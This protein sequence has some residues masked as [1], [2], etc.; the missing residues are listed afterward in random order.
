LD[1]LSSG[2]AVLGM[3]EVTWDIQDLYVVKRRM[4]TMAYYVPKADTILFSLKVYFDEQSGGYYHIIKDMT[5]L[6]LGDGTPMVF[7]YQPGNTL[8]MMLM[9]RHFNKPTT[10]VGLTFEDINMLYNLMVVD[11]VN[12]PITAAHN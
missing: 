1:G 12:Q 6:A 7:P 4:T 11:E 5:T 2:T 3:G 9:S 8:P 10:P